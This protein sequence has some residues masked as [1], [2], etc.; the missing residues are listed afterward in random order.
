MPAMIIYAYQLFPCAGYLP[1]K[2]RINGAEKKKQ[3]QLVVELHRN[4][5][6]PNQPRAYG[7]KLERSFQYKE[8]YYLY[9][10]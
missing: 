4:S 2:W 5:D 9:H 8:R 6:L 1:C 3:G 7:V 10:G